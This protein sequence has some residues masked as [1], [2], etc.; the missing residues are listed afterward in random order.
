M[1][2]WM[3]TLDSNLELREITMP[4]SHDAGIN[5]ADFTARFAPAS[6]T[7]TQDG[8]VGKQCAD[9]SRFFDIR[10]EKTGLPFGERPLR[11]FHKA[12][13]W[14]PG[15]LGTRADDIFYQVWRFLNHNPSEFVILRIS[16]TNRSSGAVDMAKSI[17]REVL[18][19][20]TGNLAKTKISAL[21]GQVICVF[22]AKEFGP[23]IDPSKGIHAFA[24]YSGAV[25]N[26]SGLYTC[27]E[28]SKAKEIHKVLS[29]QLG[30]TNE[31]YNLHYG[32][33]DHLFVLYWTQTGGNIEENTKSTA[34]NPHAKHALGGA[35][36]NMD[37]MIDLLNGQGGP[38]YNLQNF[39]AT[40][41]TG[42]KT[43]RGKKEKK[44]L[45][46]VPTTWRDRR[47]VMPNVIMY[48]FVNSATSQKIAAL[49]FPDIQAF[50]FEEEMQ[51][52]EREGIDPIVTE[53]I[54]FNR[55]TNR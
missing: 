48:D 31:H 55:K 46:V 54:R 41:E 39:T 21:Q 29:K 19:K 47:R 14:G 32:N 23:D 11:A 53:Q 12:G 44:K 38:Q 10:L 5:K 8:N 17:F 40:Q 3:S 30:R 1:N 28:F 6:S 13:D 4:G 7:V 15:G 37:Y 49:N 51:D 9:G 25:G 24:K 33:N 42:R 52:L 45:S 27:G 43:W 35:I 36:H 18:Y 16:H 26:A 22:D 34:S 20:G 50:L 2:N